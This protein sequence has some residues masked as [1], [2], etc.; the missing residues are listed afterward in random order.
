MRSPGR[1]NAHEAEAA[2]KEQLSVRQYRLIGL[3]MIA[4]AVLGALIWW[5]LITYVR[6]NIVPLGA[7]VVILALLGAFTAWTGL[8]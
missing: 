8:K 5:L 1:K 4:V 6:V 2:V 7:A 3:G